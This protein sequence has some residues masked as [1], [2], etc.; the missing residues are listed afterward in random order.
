MIKENNYKSIKELREALLRE[1]RILEQGVFTPTTYL[2]DILPMMTASLYT[3]TRSSQPRQSRSDR[4]M[5]NKKFTCAYCKGTH[6]TNNC[7]VV[8]GIEKRLKFVKRE[9]LCFN[10]LG[11]HRVSQ[12]TSQG[13]CKR[14]NNKHHTSICGA[15]SL[16][17]MKKASNTQSS[18]TNP[19]Q[20]TV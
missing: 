6:A 1:I 19:Q 18:E 8:V 3:G 20:S 13:R 14:C 10:C 9:G 5:L 2:P 11:R 15:K 16:Q 4:G 17:P 7:D 12:C